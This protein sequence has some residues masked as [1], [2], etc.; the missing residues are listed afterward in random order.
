MNSRGC[1]KPPLRRR[2]QLRLH[3]RL[4]QVFHNTNSS[5]STCMLMPLLGSQCQKSSGAT[6]TTSR[7]GGTTTTPVTTT[8][9][10]SSPNTN[11]LNTK[12]KAKGKQYWG[13]C[14]DQG[15][16]SQSQCAQVVKDDFGALTPENSL[17][18]DATCVT[19][20]SPSSCAPFL[21][22]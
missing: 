9:G 7:P 16:L 3:Q 14:G 21:T 10:G 12:Y 22:N 20:P 5:D 1:R 4:L 18:W 11:S 13:T 8:T 19:F 6:T 17:K 2:S 15:T